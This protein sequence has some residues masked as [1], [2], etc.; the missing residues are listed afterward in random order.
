[1]INFTSFGVP[2][3][4]LSF[5]SEETKK[6]KQKHRW[7]HQMTKRQRGSARVDVDGK[8]NKKVNL[9]DIPGREADK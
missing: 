4:L 7:K 5:I 6:S 8:Q 2:G 3:N 9:L 1:M